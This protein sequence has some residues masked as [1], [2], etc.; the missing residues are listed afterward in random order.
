MIKK[1]KIRYVCNLISILNYACM[2]FKDIWTFRKVTG[3]KWYS[4]PQAGVGGG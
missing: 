4:N 3:L 1:P 2:H